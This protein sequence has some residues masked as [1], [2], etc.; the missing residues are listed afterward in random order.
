VAH[1][2]A[3]LYTLQ[4]PLTANLGQL[5]NELVTALEEAGLF[6]KEAEAMVETWGDS[7]F[8]EGMRLFYIVPREQVD[9][10]LPLTITP[11][12]SS[13]QRVFVARIELLSPAIEATIRSA[14]ST[15]DV[16]SLTKYGRFLNPFLILL[17]KNG[18]NSLHTG[19]VEKALA[20]LAQR[21]KASAC[22]Q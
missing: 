9:E 12:P 16:A 20:Q 6:R 22:V 13:I 17:E 2:L 14:A 8:E 5:R 4:P 19:I 15:D 7:W 18:G 3:G 1:G 11:W 21:A 10:Q